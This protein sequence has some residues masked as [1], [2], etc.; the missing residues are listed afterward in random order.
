LTAPG[1]QCHGNS[2]SGAPPALQGDCDFMF[3]A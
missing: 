3:D 1:M 2:V